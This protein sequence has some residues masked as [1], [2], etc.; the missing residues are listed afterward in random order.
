MSM[1]TN[2]SVNYRLSEAVSQVCGRGRGRGC[3]ASVFSAGILAVPTALAQQ[4]ETKQLEAVVVSASRMEQR[5]FDA[6]AA[7][8]AV[9]VDPFRAASPLVNLSELTGAIPGL[10]V[11]DRQNFAQDLQVSVRGFG[12]RSTFGVR[13]VR[14]LVDGIPATMPDG[15][16]QAAT[17]SLTSARQIEV[18]RG[19]MAQ[20]YGN[21]AGGVLQVFTKNPPMGSEPAFVG[22][23]AGAGSDDQRQLGASV[24]GGTDTVGALLDVNRFSTDGYRDHSAA[25]R[26][27][28][29]GKLVARPSSDTTVTALYN[30]F[31]QPKAQDPL[32]LTHSDFERNPRQVVPAAITFD[33]RKSIEQQQAGVVVD[34]RLSAGDTLNARI[35][36][37]QRKINQTL[38][39]SGAAPT[40]AGGVVDLDR[41][42]DGIGLSWTHKTQANGMPLNWT[43]GFEADDQK[44][45]RRGF[46]NNNGATGALR[47]DEDDG[48]RN[49][50]V[51]AQADWTFDPQWQLIAGVRASRVR[52]SVED[53]FI[54]AASPDDSGSVRFNNT[55]PI[56]G[57][58][59]HA[60]ETM[61]VYANLG[62]GFETPTLAE[63]A[64]RAGDAT[65]PNLSLRPS[66]ST[67]AEIGMKMK[68]G[69]HALELAVFDTRSNDEIVPSQVINGRS[70]FQNVDKVE[71]RGAEASWHASWGQFG[72]RLG[73][74]WLDAQFRQGFSNAQ[75]A[76][77]AAGNRLPGAP[78]HSLFTE[79]EYKPTD[80]LTT[81][82]EMRVES[83][84][85]VDDINS[86]AAP[87]YA[88]LN[89]RSAYEFRVGSA[90]M[91]LFGRID[92]LLDK[93][94]AGSVIVNDGNGRFFEPAAG[95]RFFVGL[96][97]MF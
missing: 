90:R 61:N 49:V 71:R 91:N 80:A 34:H 64:Y 25:R 56:V 2:K 95:R 7:I 26:T 45:R 63:S 79:V 42:Y 17:A 29:N 40:S 85:Y 39:F 11:R 3:I 53:H 50:D 35:Y 16:G 55:S 69:R 97:T 83:K 22:L 58:V 47:R 27:Q 52:L 66:K 75:G 87:G 28:I 92:N 10:Q 93:N 36:A 15:Q 18:L 70:V 62:R 41:D 38:A 60:S 19:P 8:D 9:Q 33:T 43:L 74:T 65:G 31:D 84:A 44:E 59:W 57:L 21:A 20:L 1:M 4:A 23:S 78:E 94:Y 73:Y 14:I 81:A 89:L 67:Q 96:R 12:T 48:A 76:R 68:S 13:G 72:T 30:K 51:F 37:G 32:G 6:P 77:I 46:V 24:G 82:L 88:V 86:D 5:R 54:T